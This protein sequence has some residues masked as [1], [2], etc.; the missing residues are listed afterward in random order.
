M[1]ME[2]QKNIHKYDYSRTGVKT[3]RKKKK[4]R[5]VCVLIYGISGEKTVNE[6]TRCHNGRLILQ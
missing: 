2:S 3:E 1:Y 4:R 6:E 5:N